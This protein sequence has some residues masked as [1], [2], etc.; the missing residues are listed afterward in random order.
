MKLQLIHPANDNKQRLILNGYKSFPPP[1]GLEILSKYIEIKNPNIKIEIFDGNA[2]SPEV[3]LK[4]LNADFIGISDWF[5]NH[6]NSMYFAKRTKEINPLC[7]VIIGGPNATNLGERILINHPYVDF[8]VYGDGEEALYDIVKAKSNSEIPNLWYRNAKGGICFTFKKSCKI[9]DNEDFDLEHLLFN[10]ISKYDTRVKSYKQTKDLS[11]FPISSIRGCIKAQQSGPCAFCSFPSDLKLRIKSPEKFWSQIE[12]L[13]SKYGISKFLE[14]G[15]NFI[16]GNYPEKILKSKPKDLNIYLRIYANIE[17]LN[18]KNIK[19]LAGIG[20]KEIYFGI[21]NIDESVQKE[22]NKKYDSSSIFEKIEL[23]QDFG[24]H[25][26]P[27]FIF[28]LPGETEISMIKNNAFAKLL[29]YEFPSIQHISYNAWIPLIGSELFNKL[30]NDEFVFENYQLYTNKS[31][32]T[33]D[34]IDYELL[35]L[36]S[37]KRF[38]D[39]SFETF[40]N[41][42]KKPLHSRLSD[43]VAGYGG[44]ADIINDSSYYKSIAKLLDNKAANR[45]TIEESLKCC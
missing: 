41:I 13:Y 45:Y 23:I 12:L 20:V 11:P 43:Q 22:V 28:G 33:D 19:E 18:Y 38:T 32:L 44:I 26:F 36:L 4:N 14:T 3:I 17:S 29:S 27:S 25:P 10:N 42:Y 21:E 5:S 1:I 39:L 30:M 8:V 35:F 24:I 34:D 31:L 2:T 37:L 40:H 7:K 9:N 16:V 6:S 15:D